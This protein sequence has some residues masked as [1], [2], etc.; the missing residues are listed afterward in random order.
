MQVRQSGGLRRGG[1]IRFSRIPDC[2]VCGLL[3]HIPAS[4]R[5]PPCA[6]YHCY[7]HRR[8]AGPHARNCRDLWP[9]TGASRTPLI[10]PP[11]SEHAGTRRNLHLAL[12]Q[13]RK[14]QLIFMISDAAGQCLHGRKSSAGRSARQSPA[15]RRPASPHRSLPPPGTGLGRGPTRSSWTDRAGR[16]GAHTA[17]RTLPGLPRQLAVSPVQRRPCQPGYPV[18]PHPVPRARGSIRRHSSGG[19]ARLSG[20]DL[21]HG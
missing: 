13:L 8:P 1:P 16:G 19:L 12:C 18:V 20:A 11:F 3:A 2:V 4:S 10:G 21:F 5:V 14:R 9:M 15:A 6:T 7:P 17:A